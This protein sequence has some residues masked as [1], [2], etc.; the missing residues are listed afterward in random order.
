MSSLLWKS[1]AQSETI[2]D[3]RQHHNGESTS[4]ISSLQTLLI[5]LACSHL[6]D[7]AIKA[8]IY[9]DLST[10]LGASATFSVERKQAQGKMF[11]AVK[12]IITS[13][14]SF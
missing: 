10:P 5:I 3:G 6:R 13:R 9:P 1:F 11:V 4:A 8:R 12:H 14:L 7:L 2:S